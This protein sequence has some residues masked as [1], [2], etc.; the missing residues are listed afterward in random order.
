MKRSPFNLDKEWGRQIVV[1]HKNKGTGKSTKRAKQ[2]SARR[3]HNQNPLGQEAAS[4]EIGPN[5]GPSE[6]PENIT[7]A[8]NDFIAENDIRRL[9]RDMEEEDDTHLDPNHPGQDEVQEGIDQE[10]EIST[11]E[12]TQRQGA[13]HLNFPPINPENISAGESDE[14]PDLDQ[15]YPLH[16]SSPNRPDSGNPEERQLYVVGIPVAH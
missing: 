12:A 5:A 9:E 8:E 7:I 1:P 13:V 4:K 10:V 3:E 6:E 11:T 2:E 14:E 16:T 15:Y